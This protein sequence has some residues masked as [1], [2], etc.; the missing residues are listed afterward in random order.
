MNRLKTTIC[1]VEFKNPI[2][3]ASGTYG[4]GREYERYYDPAVLG[5]ISSKGITYHAK[6]GNTGIR[7][8]E[9]PSGIINSIGLENPGIEVFCKDMIED[10]LQIDTNIFVNLGGNTIEEYVEGAKMLNDFDFFAIELNISCPNVKEGGMAFGTDEE[11]AYRVVSAVRKVSKHRLFVKLS[12]NVGSIVNIAKAVERAGA[13]G[14]SLINTILAMAIDVDKMEKVFDNT[15]AGLSGPAVKP[16]ALRM[17]HEVCKNVNIPVIG[18]GGITTGIDAIEFILAGASA[19]Q[20]GTANF[21]NPRAVLEIKDQMVEYL[22][23]KDKSVDEI[24]GLV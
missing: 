15:Y 14:I 21:M 23:N 20:V 1:G 4:Y 8:W 10:M 6:E 16:I 18:M 19:V 11:A 3:T 17:T 13:D 24:R 12:P 2:I 7:I 9:T 5:G 22:D